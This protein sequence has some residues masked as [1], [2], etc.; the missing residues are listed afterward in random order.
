MTITSERSEAD[1]ELEEDSSE[2]SSINVQSF[3]DE[4]VL[5]YDVKE[6]LTCKCHFKT[7]CH[8]GTGM[9]AS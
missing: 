2:I 8:Y 3:V 5:N 1:I 6:Q 7:L 4:Q 9:E